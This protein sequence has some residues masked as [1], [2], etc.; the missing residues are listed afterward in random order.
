MLA[1]TLVMTP[2]GA[3]TPALWR[4]GGSARQF[5]T[6]KLQS[7]FGGNPVRVKELETGFYALQVEI[8]V[9]SQ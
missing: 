3:R 4:S 1:Y 6:E 7:V 9:N 2:G 8:P 5:I